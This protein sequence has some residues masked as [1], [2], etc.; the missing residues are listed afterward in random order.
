MLYVS[1]I[2]LRRLPPETWGQRLERARGDLTQEQA[3]EI[4]SRVHNV[5][6]ATIAR[7]ERLDGAPPTTSKNRRRVAILSILAYGYD[8][9]DFGLSIDELP[10]IYGGRDRVVEALRAGP[11]NPRNYLPSAA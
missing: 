8:P 7:L 5:S 9:E 1:D 11:E 10:P 2:A 3:A 4:V 6:H